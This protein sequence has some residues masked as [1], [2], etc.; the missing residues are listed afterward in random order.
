MYLHCHH[1][2]VK[3]HIAAFRFFGFHRRVLHRRVFG[4]HRRVLHRLVF[5]FGFVAP[6]SFSDELHC[7]LFA[8]PSMQTH[9]ARLRLLFSSFLPGGMVQRT[10]LG[11]PFLMQPSAI[12]ASMGL[13]A[14]A[15]VF[16]R[17]CLCALLRYE[18]KR[19]KPK[20]NASRKQ[21]RR[22]STPRTAKPK[23]DGEWTT[24]GRELEPQS[25]QRTQ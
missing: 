3:F 9:K 21:K 16:I 12:N 5:T 23:P 6:F 1:R 2:V 7:S 20:K 22:F 8:S 10:R 4:F 11:E 17:F 14:H 13:E 15:S 25:F 18:V 19:R 24:L